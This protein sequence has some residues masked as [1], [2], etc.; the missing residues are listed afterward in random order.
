LTD[1]RNAERREIYRAPN[2]LMNL[3]APEIHFLRNDYYIYFALDDGDNAN[4]R[5]FVIK[6]LDNTN[7]MGDWSGEKRMVVPGDDFWS[8]DATPLLYGN[9]RLY[10]IWSGWPNIDSGFPQNLYIAPMSDPMTISGPR[11]L[12][13]TP[14][15]QWDQID[16]PINEGPQVL[17]HMGR[18]FVVFSG[19]GSWGPDYCLGIMGIDDLKDPLVASNWWDDVDRPVFWRNDAESVYGTGHA[20]FANSPD[21]TESYIVYHAMQHPAGGWENR[22]ARAERFHWNPDHSPAFPRPRSFAV[23]HPDPSGQILD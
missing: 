10:L 8:I 3:W 7:P 18:T 1:F 22:T 21:G 9:G 12:I 16:A 17:Q 6:A 4:H 15:N 20:S 5:T 19:S 14:H 23:A 13:R 2:G 11:V